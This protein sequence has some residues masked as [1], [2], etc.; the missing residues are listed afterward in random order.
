M[1]ISSAGWCCITILGLATIIAAVI[2]Y[3]FEPGSEN[4]I[5]ETH[6]CVV[7][8][9]DIFGGEYTRTVMIDKSRPC[10]DIIASDIDG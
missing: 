5:P 6:K 4:I 10:S 1:K 9:K 2:I 7:L 3:T 8:T